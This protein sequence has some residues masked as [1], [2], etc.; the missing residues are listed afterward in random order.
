[1]V[2]Y[3]VGVRLTATDVSKPMVDVFR[4]K[5]TA[6]AYEVND[7]KIKSKSKKS[8]TNA[9]DES[10]RTPLV[11]N[12]RLL[13]STH[14]AD[15]QNTQLPGN[16][17]DSV[18]DTFGLCSFED[19]VRALREMG[20]VCRKVTVKNTKTK[21]SKLLKNNLNASTDANSNSNNSNNS[22]R[23][24]LLEHGRSDYVWLNNILDKHADKHASHWGCYWNRDIEGIV[25][26]S[27]LKIVEMKKFHFGTTYYIVCE[28]VGEE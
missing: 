17:F 9:N 4:E 12:T 20:R 24:Y 16:S 19:P 5:A 3:P 28:P 2:Y 21:G 14:I 11:S 8:E 6:E 27:G 23:I 10:S 13:V 22:G 1:M 7:E 15:T 18:V 25:K 26:Q